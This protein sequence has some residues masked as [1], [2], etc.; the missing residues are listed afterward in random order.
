MSDELYINIMAISLILIIILF[1]LVKLSLFV[2]EV[3]IKI[4]HRNKPENRRDINR[5]YSHNDK[6]KYSTL[7]NN[8]CEGIGIFL[9]CR[10]EGNDLQGDHWYPYS[11]GGATTKKNLVMLCPKCN[12]KKTNHVPTFLQTKAIEF[13]R[14]HN[15][16]YNNHIYNKPGEWLKIN[17]RRDN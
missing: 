6:V 3:I 5:L 12:K 9:R 13:R 14:K 2:E 4:F 11:R 8:R 1:I 17:Y 7:C 15:M 16:G 10:H